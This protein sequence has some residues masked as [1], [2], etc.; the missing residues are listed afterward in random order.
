MGYTDDSDSSPPTPTTASDEENT[1]ATNGRISPIFYSRPHRR[2]TSLNINYPKTPISIRKGI[3]ESEEIWEE[4]EDD[5]VS[6]LVPFHQ[7]RASARSTPSRERKSRPQSGDGGYSPSE[8]SAL[9]GRT[10]T[11]RSYRDRRRRSAPGLNIQ[12]LG[13]GREERRSSGQQ[14][15]LG[16]WWKMRWW[17]DMGRGKST[18]DDTRRDGEG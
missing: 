4:L 6:P 14:Q 7:R 11:G 12:G 10:G 1:L 5:A 16:G 13:D 15:A 18:H 3:T 8:S 17:K 9:L 2:S